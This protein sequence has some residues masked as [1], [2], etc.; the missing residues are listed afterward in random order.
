MADWCEMKRSIGW[1]LGILC[2]LD[3]GQSLKESYPR[4]GMADWHGTKKMWLIHSWPWY[5]LV[6]PWWGGRMY[7]IVTGVTSDVGVPSTYLVQRYPLKFHIKYLTYALKDMIFMQHW[8]FKSSYIQ[9]LIRIL[10]PPGAWIPHDF[11]PV[12]DAVWQ[13]I[14][15]IS[16]VT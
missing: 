8:N 15:Q 6:W 16:G 13:F 4:D 1:I 14:F 2:D 10:K 7:R 11:W 3:L 9:E 5:W 12:S